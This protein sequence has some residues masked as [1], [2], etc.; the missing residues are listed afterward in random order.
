MHNSL[1]FPSECS[2]RR[3]KRKNDKLE[4]ERENDLQREKERERNTFLNL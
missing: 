3:E 2:R 1:A 4:K